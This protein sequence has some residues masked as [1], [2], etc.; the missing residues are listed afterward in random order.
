MILVTCTIASFVTQRGAQNVA[1]ADIS[2][3]ELSGEED[4]GDKILIPLSNAENVE[5]LITL[6]TT[7]KPR[8]CKAMMMALS[9]IKSD[10]ND[11]SRRKDH[12]LYWIKRRR[13][14]QLPIMRF[15]D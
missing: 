7:V 14:Q 6:G 11:L 4:T 2:A 1:I 9:I 8:K 5:E 12:R 15:R 3:E 13:R 10:S